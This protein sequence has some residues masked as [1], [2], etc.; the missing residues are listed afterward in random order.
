[1]AN[2]KMNGIEETVP[3][4]IG[5]AMD[6]EDA[7]VEVVDDGVRLD[8]HLEKVRGRDGRIYNNFLVYVDLGDGDVMKAEMRPKGDDK[9]TYQ[10]LEK[11]FMSHGG[12]VVPIAC[13]RNSMIDSA[14]KKNK[15]WTYEV[16]GVCGG[17]PLTVRVSPRT[18]GSKALIAGLIDAQ[19]AEKEVQ[20]KF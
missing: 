4:S 20:G 12:K 10:V 14:G 18:E 15:Y 7:G 6:E 17:I 3:E 11:I 5:Y 8:L 2:E 16:S 1:M 13:K 9:Q 19:L